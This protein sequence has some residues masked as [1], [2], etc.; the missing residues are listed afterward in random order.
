MCTDMFTDID[1]YRD[2]GWTSG[3]C[4]AVCADMC[5][6]VCADMCAAMCADMCVDMCIDK[7]VGIGTD[8]P[9]TSSAAVA[10]PDGH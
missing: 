8:V 7:C 6:A 2:I 1:M 3:V 9:D 4:A 10:S 5:A